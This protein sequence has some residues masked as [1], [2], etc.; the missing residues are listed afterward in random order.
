MYTYTGA[1][2]SWKA[3][4]L[5]RHF[6]VTDFSSSDF[7]DIFQNSKTRTRKEESSYDELCLP[8]PYGCKIGDCLQHSQNCLDTS[9]ACLGVP[10]SLLAS[11]LAFCLGSFRSFPQILERGKKMPSK[12]LPHPYTRPKSNRIKKSKSFP[13]IKESDSDRGGE[14]QGCRTTRSRSR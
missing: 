1:V 12:T 4:G 7:Q 9:T 2:G 3:L 10:G 8:R 6:Q 14:P 13:A 11:G 5:G